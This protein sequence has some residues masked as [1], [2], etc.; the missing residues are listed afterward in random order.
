MTTRPHHP[1]PRPSRPPGRRSSRRRAWRDDSGAVTLEA[2]FMVALL[3]LLLVVIVA[4]GRLTHAD[5]TV[6]AAAHAAARAASLARSPGD[7]QTQAHTAAADSVRQGGSSCRQLTVIVDTTDFTAGGA[8]T[9][10]LDC[11][12]TLSDLGLLGLPGTTTISGNATSPL[13]TYRGT[14]S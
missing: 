3:L 12:V 1:R 9:V 10:T 13:D 2:I 6:D 8:V 14:T 5:Q 4:L 7:A 11:S